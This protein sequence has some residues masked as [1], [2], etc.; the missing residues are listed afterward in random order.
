MKR[1]DF[2][3]VFAACFFVS[4][5]QLRAASIDR[6]LDAIK[7]VESGG[8]NK[9][10][11]DGGKARGGYQLWYSFY[12]DGKPGVVREYGECPSYEVTA[13]SDV[14]ARRVIISWWRRYAS[15]A[16]ARGDFE[17]LAR[18]FNGGPRGERV[19]ATEKY[20]VKVRREM[21]KSKN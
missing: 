7:Q 21:D 5:G 9:A 4:A 14:W 20:W 10:V 19:A 12:T 18:R 3:I 6:L 17:T 16:L 15:E 1:K 8:N 11:G 2:L 13:A